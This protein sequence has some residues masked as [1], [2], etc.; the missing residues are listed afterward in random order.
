MRSPTDTP[1]TPS[2]Q[3]HDIVERLQDVNK[4]LN[5]PHVGFNNLEETHHLINEKGTKAFDVELISL[6]TELHPNTVRKMI[7][8]K[9]YFLNAKLSNVEKF[10]NAIGIELWAK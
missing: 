2:Q 9:E 6:Q 10:L 8:N 3:L 1:K 5:V 7:K 4:Q